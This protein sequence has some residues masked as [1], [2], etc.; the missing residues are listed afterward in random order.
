MNNEKNSD[1]DSSSVAAVTQTAFD[2]M[3]NG[4]AI[5]DI[6]VGANI[7]L[8]MLLDHKRFT[9]QRLYNKRAKDGMIPYLVPT[10][11]VLSM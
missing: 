7:V 10:F 11:A 5:F 9:L 2:F 6:K 1:K 3:S 4:S 8:N